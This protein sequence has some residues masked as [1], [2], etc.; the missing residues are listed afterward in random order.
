MAA[1][2]VGPGGREFSPWQLIADLYDAAND[3]EASTLQELLVKSGW[4]WLCKCRVVV[5]YDTDA[6]PDCGSIRKEV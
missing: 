4:C 6:C 2:K 3:D 1:R 5:D